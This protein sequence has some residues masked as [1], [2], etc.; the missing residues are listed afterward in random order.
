[1]RKETEIVEM[2][3]D[4]SALRVGHLPLLS[5]RRLA[6]KS[7]Q[8]AALIRAGF[9]PGHG[10]QN[11]MIHR[12][13]I[14]ETLD[15]FWCNHSITDDLPHQSNTSF[16]VTV[17]DESLA[18]AIN[19]VITQLGDPGAQTSENSHSSDI[20][21]LSRDEL[22]SGA[23]SSINRLIKTRDALAAERDALA[24]ER[25]ALAAERDA[26]VV[27][28]DALVVERDALA[29]ERDGLA[30]ERD[31]LA[32]EVERL[33]VRHKEAESVAD[34]RRQEI[35]KLTSSKAFRLGMLIT[36]PARHLRSGI[37]ALKRRP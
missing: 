19:I 8:G 28:R 34:V 17:V 31:A 16:P 18:Q 9:A 12:M 3:M 29:V 21:G 36:W 32:A 26:L 13:Q 4:A 30:V 37:A 10:W 5:Q 20:T 23:I 24:A 35:T 15:D 27:E 11:Q 14:A 33:Q 2:T 7:E 22:W 6:L 1:M 25:D